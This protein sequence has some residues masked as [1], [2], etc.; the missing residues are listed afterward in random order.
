MF[1]IL[2]IKIIVSWLDLHGKLLEQLLILVPVYDVKLRIISE[3]WFQLDPGEQIV[4]LLFLLAEFLLDLVGLRH[5][6]SRIKSLPYCFVGDQWKNGSIKD[7]SLGKDRHLGAARWWVVHASTRAA[8]VEE[9]WQEL[10]LVRLR[11][12]PDNRRSRAQANEPPRGAS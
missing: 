5:S 9:P 12:R 10:P 8:A 11:C 2:P 1:K 7:A 4:Q 3:A 6:Q